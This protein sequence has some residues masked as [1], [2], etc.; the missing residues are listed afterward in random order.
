MTRRCAIYT[1]VST[2]HQAEHGF[3]LE[4]QRRRL[5][6]HAETMGWTWTIYEDPGRSGET[7]EG[8]PGMMELLSAVDRGEVDVVLVVDESRLSRD[9]LTG[10]VIR[11]RLS[12]AGVTL[13]T[14]GGE[15]DLDD[16]SQRFTAKVLGAV[17]E[18]EQG[19][20]T[21]KTKRGLQAAASSGFWPGGPAPFGYRIAPDPKGSAHRVLAIDESEAAV[22]RRAVQLILDEGLSAWH[23]C[24][25]LNAEGHGPRRAERWHWRNL[26]RTLKSTALAGTWL[27]RQSDRDIPMRVP[28]IVTRD[29]W[30]ALQ[31]RIRE[32]PSGKPKKRRTYPLTG[33]ARCQCGGAL[34]GVWRKDHGRRYY[35]C[36]MNSSEFGERR[37]PVYPRQRRADRLE[38]RV[39]SLVS[40]AL[41]DPEYLDGLITAAE[42][43]HR[44]SA[45][46]QSDQLAAIRRRIAEY[47]AQQI[48]VVRDVALP[49]ELRHRALAEIEE[50]LLRARQRESQLL[51]WEQLRQRRQQQR[52]AVHRLAATARQRLDNPTPELMVEAYR[53]FALQVQETPDGLQVHGVIPIPDDGSDIPLAA[54]VGGEVRAEAPRV[55]APRRRRYGRDAGAARHGPGRAG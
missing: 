37:C 11:D 38:Q 36:S 53:L 42:R 8:R 35:D 20:R 9:D 49:E 43:D 26:A 3:S 27:Y 44:M 15:H 30:E 12:R 48:R 29:R 40:A 24:K 54:A 16:P 23:A 13:A 18:M 4:D 41:T 2:S 10:A 17:H 32:R 46:T 31:G 52:H 7:L 6:A 22:I 19:L 14:P 25:Q 1:R 28:A 39:W 55:L 33:R 45:P 47:E 51:D 5:T 34:S 21:A 50:D